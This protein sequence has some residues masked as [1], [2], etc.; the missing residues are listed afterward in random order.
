VILVRRGGGRLRIEY[1]KSRRALRLW[2]GGPNEVEPIDLTLADFC[3]R[4]GIERHVIGGDRCFVLLGGSLDGFGGGQHG[5]VRAFHCE[6]EAR[7]G[8]MA[9]RTQAPEGEWGRLIAI[10]ERCA[11]RTVAW[12]G[13][14]PPGRR[15]ATASATF[16]RD[17]S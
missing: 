10:D 8:F 1:S 15:P 2:L 17:E 6:G 12:F 16:E 3:D 4:L 11:V 7:Q 14:P 5:V 13:T 9:R